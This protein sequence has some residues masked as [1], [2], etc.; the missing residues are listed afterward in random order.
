M[1]VLQLYRLSELPFLSLH[2]NL[3]NFNQI[4]FFQACTSTTPQNNPIHPIRI[5][6]MASP[7]SL[8]FPATATT[9]SKPSICFRSIKYIPPTLHN[10]ARRSLSN[11]VISNF[12]E[13]YICIYTD[14][15]LTIELSAIWT[16]WAKY[17]SPCSSVFHPFSA[18]W[19]AAKQPLHSNIVNPLSNTNRAWRPFLPDLNVEPK[20][21]TK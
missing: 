6:L 14:P 11:S 19:I 9:R 18:F 20:N 3:F 21:R 2:N 17:L 10:Q 15:C 12:E 7:T 8:Y 5:F 4:T 16:T 13:Q 1:L